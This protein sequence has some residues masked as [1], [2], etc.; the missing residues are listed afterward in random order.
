MKTFKSDNCSGVHPLI[1]AALQACNQ[2]HA[3]SYGAD[4]FTARA[5]ELFQQ[6]FA[7][8]AQAMLVPTGTGANILALKCALRPY[9]SVICAATAHIAV[10]ETGAAEQMVGCKLLTVP[11][12]NGKL[13]PAQVRARY[14]AE[15]SGGPH[16]TQPKLVSVAQCTEYGTVYRPAELAAL[17]TTCH[18]LG[19]WLHIDGCRVYNAAAYL[20]CSLAQAVAHADLLSLGGT[21]NGAMLAEAVLVFNPA[22]QE[23]LA[24]LHKN[25]LQLYSKN[26]FVAAQFIAL[27]E[28]QLWQQNAA[29]ANQVAQ[30][31]AAGL[32][33]LPGVSLAQPVESNHVFVNLPL[34]V[35]QQLQADGWG[36][37]WQT[38]PCEVRFVAS[39]DSTGAEARQLVDYLAAKLA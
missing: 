25:T 30:T 14:L 31:L 29:Q 26:R 22:M 35:A 33:Q 28:G 37:V 17:A 1:M 19:L 10:A 23:G 32:A 9:Q 13:T 16:A 36:Y 39:F 34:P 6:T 18:E 11:T 5:T 24:Y 2:G 20:G 27:L 21:K 15:T 7:R 3:L 12:P 38:D 4:P 8:P